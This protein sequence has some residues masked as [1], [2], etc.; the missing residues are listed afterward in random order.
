MWRV[1]AEFPD[2]QVC[3]CG[4]VISM[5]SGTPKRLKQ[6][7]RGAGHPLMA[8][9]LLTKGL[10]SMKTVSVSRLVALA[11]V[12]NESKAPLVMHRDDDTKNNAAANLCWGTPAEN[13]ADMVRKNRQAKGSAHG[14]SKLDEASV[15]EIKRRLA[16]GD[17]KQSIAT[18]YEVSWTAI[19]S[20]AKG[21]TWAHVKPEGK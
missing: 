15:A 2:Y 17:T 21:D 8:V 3:D 4:A 9:N 19:A 18:T 20:I 11:F 6:F 13:S 1:I 12:P 5:K 7:S 16:A 10:A 14:F